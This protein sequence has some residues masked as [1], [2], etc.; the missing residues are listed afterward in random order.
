MLKNTTVLIT[1]HLC[2]Y[3]AVFVIVERPLYSNVQSSVVG[4]SGQIFPKALVTSNRMEQQKMRQWLSFCGMLCFSATFATKNN[5]WSTKFPLP[6]IRQTQFIP[7]ENMSKEKMNN[8][9][10]SHFLE[11]FHAF[12]K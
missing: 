12:E 6:S 7:H 8:F 10:A 9:L 5:F 4:L 1:A 2:P 11:V 3:S